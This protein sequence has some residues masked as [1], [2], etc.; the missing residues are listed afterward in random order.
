MGA[1]QNG[2]EHTLRSLG[3]SSENLS[4]ANSR[5]RD[6]DIAKEVTEMQRRQAMYQASMQMISQANQLPRSL[7]KLLG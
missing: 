3:V 6:A 5:I 2:L 7:L 4:L 1:M